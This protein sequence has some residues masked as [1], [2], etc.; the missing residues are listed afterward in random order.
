MKTINRLNVFVL[1]TTLALGGNTL[2]AVSLTNGGF[3]TINGVV[4]AP[5][6][7]INVNPGT[8]TSHVGTNMTVN[9]TGF[10]SDGT[11]AVVPEP[12][13]LSLLILGGLALMI[14]RRREI[15]T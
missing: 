3:E 7:N 13:T 11:L 14:R 9:G 4:P 15:V 2:A 10:Y 12:A 1:G 6:P 8:W 5:S